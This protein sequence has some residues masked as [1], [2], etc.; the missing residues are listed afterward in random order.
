MVLVS[1]NNDKE[2][3]EGV[4]DREESGCED[5]EPS[6]LALFKFMGKSGVRIGILGG[7]A[8]ADDRVGDSEAV[9]RLS[10][11]SLEI[12]AVICTAP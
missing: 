2:E 10:D 4:S 5:D 9:L 3:E 11:S 6:P 12:A 1:A 7:G 8:G